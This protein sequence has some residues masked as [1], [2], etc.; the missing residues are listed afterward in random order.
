MLGDVD[1]TGPQVAEAGLFDHLAPL[2]VVGDPQRQ[3]A[4]A[5]LR[6]GAP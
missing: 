6:A 2:V 5:G 4:A 3:A 1:L